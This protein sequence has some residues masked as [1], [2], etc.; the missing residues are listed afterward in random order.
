MLFHVCSKQEV[1]KYVAFKWKMADMDIHEADIC[2]KDAI[3]EN[4]DDLDLKELLKLRNEMFHALDINECTTP[5]D[6]IDGKK[7]QEI[8]MAT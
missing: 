4:P 1:K 7:W 8:L 2:L 6:N 5:K 3:K